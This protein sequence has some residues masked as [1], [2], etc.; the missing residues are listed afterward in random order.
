MI[1]SQIRS[2]GRWLA[3]VSTAAFGR[4]LILGSAGYAN[5]NVAICPNI[6]AT[7]AHYYQG[8]DEIY[9]ALGGWIHIKTYDPKTAQYAE[10]RLGQNEIAPLLHAGLIPKG[11]TCTISC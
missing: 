6:K 4:T 8:F 3:V 10:Q 9:F 5:L 1:Q 2:Y 7:I 11:Q